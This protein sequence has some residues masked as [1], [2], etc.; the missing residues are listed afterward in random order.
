MFLLLVLIRNPVIFLRAIFLGSIANPVSAYGTYITKSSTFFND[1][2]L[3]GIVIDRIDGKW[4]LPAWYTAVHAIARME[5]YRAGREYALQG[6]VGWKTWRKALGPV[7]P[8]EYQLFELA[9]VCNKMRGQVPLYTL[10]LSRSQIQLES[11]LFFPR[12]LRCLLGLLGDAI[13]GRVR[14]NESRRV[15]VHVAAATAAI[16]VLVALF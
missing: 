5:L 11:L 7:T 6:N 3:H 8:G 12:Y 15:F 9:A 10:G 1:V 4:L 14:G 16:V 2:N 13:Q